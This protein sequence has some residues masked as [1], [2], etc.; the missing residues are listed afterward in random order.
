MT[1][2]TDEQLMAYSDGELSADECRELESMLAADPELRRR[3]GPFALTGAPLANV[4]SQPM[5]EP[6]PDRLVAAIRNKSMNG[7]AYAARGAATPEEYTGLGTRF[8]SAVGDFLFPNGMGG[9]QMGGAAASLLAGVVVAGWMLGGAESGNRFLVS[10]GAMLVASGELAFALEQKV[11]GEEQVADG[12]STRIFPMQTFR[13]LTQRFCRE[14]EMSVSGNR[15]AGVACRTAQGDWHVAFHGD[16]A[17]QLK[18][19]L[20]A[21]G[22]TAL[23]TAIAALK[24][25]GSVL[26]TEAEQA[27][28]E[29]NWSTQSK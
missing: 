25:E 9:L 5:R 17:P 7:A 20:A 21:P 3:L 16:K 4:F 19:G 10:K 24:D 6:V 12:A 29:G 26:S 23:D 28:I 11:S 2:V 1:L 14:Y 13:D 18:P 15:S 8:L 22:P 27:A